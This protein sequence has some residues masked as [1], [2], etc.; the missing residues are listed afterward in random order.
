MNDIKAQLKDGIPGDESILTEPEG[1][2]RTPASAF[3]I[4]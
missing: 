1:H 2:G 3:K 4:T